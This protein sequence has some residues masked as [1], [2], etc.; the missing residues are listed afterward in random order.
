MQPAATRT[1]QQKGQ[2]L[3]AFLVL[4]PVFLVCL[5]IVTD[6]GRLLYLK[7][8]VRITA[9]A[10]ALAAAGAADMRR[11]SA[12]ATCQLNRAW[13]A[14]RA[15]QVLTE[16]HS[17]IGED[18]WM[19]IGISLLQ[20]DGCSVTVV[21]EGSGSTL[22]GAYAGIDRLHARAVSHAEAVFQLP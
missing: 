18:A 6:L 14:S 3:L 5:F 2:S 15:R 22:F 9:D 4:F 11:T 19:Q 17:T 10:A 12:A 8:Q 1:H 7:N 21:I 16:M 13:A 20:V